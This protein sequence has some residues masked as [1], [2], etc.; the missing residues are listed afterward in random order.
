M[1]EANE[2]G[3]ALQKVAP[4]DLKA[5]INSDEF[6]SALAQAL[7]AHMTP[8]RYA[9]ICLT[10]MMKT[11]KLR[12]CTQASLFK[13]MLDCSSMGL[14]PDGRRA[15]LIPYW[16]TK[17][18]IYEAQLII[19]Y[20][21]LVELMKRSGEVTSIRAEVVCQ[22]DEFA[23]ENGIVM[24]KIDWR[25]PRGDVQAVYSHVKNK[26]GID[27][28]EVMTLHDVLAIRKRS[29]AKDS[30]PW[31]TDFNE[32]AKKTIIRR[33]SKKITLSPE[34]NDALEKDGDTFERVDTS[35][36]TLDEIMPKAQ[37]EVDAEKTVIING[38]LVTEEQNKEA[39]A[40]KQPAK[41]DP[42]AR[43]CGDSLGKILAA[44]NE[45]KID[46]GKFD[47]YIANVVGVKSIHELKEKD[48]ERICAWLKNLSSTK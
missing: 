31:E 8:D 18:G 2:P 14:E 41:P 26:D 9:R 46:K 40:E 27:E 38:G 34:L 33:H 23:W 13:A 24:H 42:D 45:S 12:E 20:K 16:N 29:K 44:F 6:K 28:Y 15:H 21:G 36:F 22:H 35:A 48:V 47:A 25:K 4:K 39:P 43:V 11:P 32:M 1:N 10:A 5:W 30:G 19:D 37:S 7:P 17:A 3:M